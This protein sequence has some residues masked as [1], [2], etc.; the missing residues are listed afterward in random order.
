MS[1]LPHAEPEGR[2][3]AAPTV[4]LSIEARVR[5]LGDGFTV[6]RLLPAAARRMVGPFIFLDHMGP[7]Q[8]PPGDGVGIRPHP[9]VNLATVTY[10]FEG[11]ILH[12]DSIGSEQLIRPGAVNWMTAGRGIAHSERS[13]A[14]VRKT[15]ARV[16]G[17]QLWV[18]LP[19]AQEEVA[20]SFQHRAAESIPAIERA[21][22][23]LR[24]V[25]GSAYDVTSPVEV[26]S[27]LFYVEAELDRDAVLALPDDFSGRAA[28]VV[29]GAVACD[30][31]RYGEGNLI[32]FREGPKAGIAAVEPARVMLIGGE[33]LDGP[34]HI[35]WNFV[36]S[37]AER[38]E[39]AKRDWSEGRFAEIP[40]DDRERIPLPE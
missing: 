33:P 13:P 23:R 25:A 17:L 22:A 31:K 18:A 38:I 3:P 40:G 14:A 26:L 9:H 28:Y 16:H 32:V 34:R 39:Q 15:G 2:D 19:T 5:S 10:L 7:V 4:A 6:R 1:V 30:G 8:M 20:P 11:E 24:V 37:R 21:G 29:H 12:R 36:S 27:P 35:W